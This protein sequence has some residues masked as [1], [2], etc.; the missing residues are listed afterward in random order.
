ML[1]AVRP[2]TGDAQKSS[3][4]FQHPE[5]GRVVMFRNAHSKQPSIR[6][7][8]PPKLSRFDPFCRSTNR[9]NWTSVDDSFRS[10]SVWSS[11]SHSISDS[12]YQKRNKLIMFNRN[13]ESKFSK[14]SRKKQVLSA[15]KSMTKY[16]G[17]RISLI[18]RFKQNQ[19]HGKV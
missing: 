1:L 19:I 5:V 3:A 17:P 2:R 15:I 13:H 11:S 9:R 8:L 12:E 18:A 16:K 7:M 6:E 10:D 4:G 14:H